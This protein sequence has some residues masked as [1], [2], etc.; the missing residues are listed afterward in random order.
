M[1]NPWHLRICPSQGSRGFSRL[2]A[3]TLGNPAV[4]L[5]SWRSDVFYV[6][7]LVMEMAWFSPRNLECGLLCECTKFTWKAESPSIWKYANFRRDENAPEIQR[8]WISAVSL[9]SNDLIQCDI[10]LARSVTWL[11]SN[12]N[13][14]KWQIGSHRV[15]IKGFFLFLTSLSLILPL[16]VRGSLS[17][18]SLQRFNVHFHHYIN[19]LRF[20][21]RWLLCKVTSRYLLPLE[22]DQE[23]SW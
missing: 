19:I 15:Q 9:S 13:P 7:C 2:T 3:A 21:V 11:H 17:N 22:N 6:M 23:I 20:E 8:I 10:F 12:G 1:Q 18:V 5:G 14:V 4:L 16:F